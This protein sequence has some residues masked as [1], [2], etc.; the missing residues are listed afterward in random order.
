MRMHA[1]PPRA[2]APLWL[3]LTCIHQAVDAHLTI[4]WDWK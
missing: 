4:T 3:L 2:P 1:S